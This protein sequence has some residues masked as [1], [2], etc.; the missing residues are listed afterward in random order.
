M[1]SGKRGYT[2]NLSERAEVKVPEVQDSRR[3]E[4]PRVASPGRIT[5]F[6]CGQ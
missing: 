2:P 6:G 4:G 3:A 5:L 1:C